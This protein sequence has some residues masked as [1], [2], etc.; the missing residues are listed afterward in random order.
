MII[1]IINRALTIRLYRNGDNKIAFIP[2]NKY[3]EDNLINKAVCEGKRFASFATKTNRYLR[4]SDLL[5]QIIPGP[6]SDYL[7]A[8]QANPEKFSLAKFPQFDTQ[9]KR[10]SL[11][12]EGNRDFFRLSIKTPLEIKSAFCIRRL[13]CLGKRG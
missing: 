3:I 2:L 10:F 4:C 6:G 11:S 8:F 9:E 13:Q 12:V 1:Q 5:E 7:F